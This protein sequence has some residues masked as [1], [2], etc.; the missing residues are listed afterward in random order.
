MLRV[1]CNVKSCCVCW[2]LLSV[3]L[4]VRGCQRLSGLARSEAAG[5]GCRGAAG[6]GAVCQEV[7]R[8]RARALGERHDVQ[9]RHARQAQRLRG[10][11]REVWAGGELSSL[12]ASVRAP[13]AAA[14]LQPCQLS[15]MQLST[16]ANAPA[17]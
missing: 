13:A 10:L 3:L 7:E 14:A 9:A 17:V 16:N 4:C 6:Q 15:T 5:L 1:E 8:H 2:L 11:R 12:R